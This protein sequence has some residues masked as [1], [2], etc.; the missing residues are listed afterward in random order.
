MTAAAHPGRPRSLGAGG[1]LFSL[2]A[3]LSGLSRCVPW[4]FSSP[5]F[6][7]VSLPLAALAPPF[8]A[9]CFLKGLVLKNSG[10]QPPF[11]RPALYRLLELQ[12]VWIVL[13]ILAYHALAFGIG[14]FAAI[15]ME[16]AAAHKVLQIGTE[17]QLRYSRSLQYMFC[18]AALVLTAALVLMESMVFAAAAGSSS[19]AAVQACGRNLP[20]Y[21]LL[22][23]AAV[24]CFTLCERWFA[25]FKL[26]YLEGYILEREAFNPT[27]PF[28]LL[29]F[30]LGHA[31]AF[32]L[33]QTAAASLGLCRIRG[34]V[35][36]GSSDA[37]A[38]AQP[39]QRRKRDRR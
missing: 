23:C 4:Y 34:F 25:V 27:W 26:R 22:F 33:A 29:R 2:G 36:R 39:Q 37:G 38:G 7:F 20:G 10:S 17:E 21:V 9:L 12:A 11:S 19:G 15:Y 32:A 8:Y 24:C 18:A 6:C 31:F 16:E 30:Y 13:L 3:G 28:L 35:L 5:L 14:H 1:P